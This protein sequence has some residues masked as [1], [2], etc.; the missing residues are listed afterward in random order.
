MRVSAGLPTG[1]EGLTYPIPFSDPDSL[2]GIAQH[3][4]QLLIRCEAAA[5]AWTLRNDAA[6]VALDRRLSA[7]AARRRCPT[8]TPGAR[9][10]RRWG[11]GD[12]LVDPRLGAD[13]RVDLHA[14]PRDR[15]ARGDGGG[16]PG[17]GAVVLNPVGS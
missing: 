17:A 1:M 13:G 6:A 4:D 12:D 8:P 7:R 10:A 2:I 14:E 5:S 16:V 15:G 3:E 11:L 9:G